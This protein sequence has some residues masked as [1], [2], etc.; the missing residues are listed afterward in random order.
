MAKPLILITPGYRYPEGSAAQVQLSMDYVRA[1][2]ENGGIAVLA[3]GIP[4]AAGELALRMDGLLLSGGCDVDP[5]QFGQEN[6]GTED[7]DKVRDHLELAL[8]RAMLAL[9]KPVLGI[10]RGIQVLNVALGGTLVQ[11]IPSWL[12]I[13]HL[14][15]TGL[16]H[17]VQVREGC[18]LAPQIS[19][20][21]TVNSTHHQAVDQLGQGLI[22]VAHSEHGR[23]IEAVE[24][25]DGRPVWGVQWHPE[26]LRREDPVMDSIFQKLVQAAEAFSAK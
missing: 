23:I 22:A 6:R 24:A 3:A 25:D 20:R 12:G 2:E 5:A 4:E 8:C 14:N 11:D 7:I 19:G 16:R 10:C 17:T 21:W 15:G 26:R 18:F 9:N 1:V 13:D